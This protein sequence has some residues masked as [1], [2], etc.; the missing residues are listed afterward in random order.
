MVYYI[1]TVEKGKTANGLLFLTIV[2]GCKGWVFGGDW[3]VVVE[4]MQTF[5]Y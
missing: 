3:V 1:Y 5:F 2:K 4:R